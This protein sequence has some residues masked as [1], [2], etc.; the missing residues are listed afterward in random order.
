MSLC[1]E[2]CWEA[3][4]DFSLLYEGDLDVVRPIGDA[5]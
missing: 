5:Q 3:P 2:N 1:I 4:P